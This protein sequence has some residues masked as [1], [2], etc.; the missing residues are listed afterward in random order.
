MD[1]DDRQELN[2]HLKVIEENDH[3][4]INAHNKQINVNLEL[5]QNI[6]LL[7]EKVNENIKVYNSIL[8]NVN[9]TQKKDIEA[10]ELIHLQIQD[11]IAFSRIGILGRNILTYEEIKKFEINKKKL[12]YIKSKVLEINKNLIIVIMIPQ[13]CKEDYFE[14]EILPVPNKFNKEINI[15]KQRYITDTEKVYDYTDEIIFKERLNLSYK[16]IQNIFKSKFKFCT[17]RTHNETEIKEIEKG[18][19]FTKSLE[20]TKIKH[21]CNKMKYVIQGNNIIEFKKCS[22]SINENNFEN[23]DNIFY[24]LVILPFYEEMNVTSNINS[25]EN[26]HL[27]NIENTKQ[28]KEL[29]YKH[30]TNENYSISLTIK[31]TIILISLLTKYCLKYKKLC[32]RLLRKETSNPSIEHPNIELQEQLKLK[33][34]G[35]THSATTS[36][37]ILTMNP[38]EPKGQR[39]GLKDNNSTEENEDPA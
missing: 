29:K 14:I 30:T 2:E 20:K 38:K 35:V 23:F 8:N 36:S 39:S 1:D 7:S 26:V 24:N 5:Q 34:G 17:S 37:A 22:I 9:I 25:L 13:F 10:I 4:L 15:D 16:C 11:L 21:D 27:K 19:V 3:K 18:I 28:I 31:I 32:K 12:K 6:D 33:E